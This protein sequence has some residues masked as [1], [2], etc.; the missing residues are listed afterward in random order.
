MFLTRKKSNTTEKDDTSAIIA[1]MVDRTQ[2]T[3]QF[4]PDGTI[5]TANQNF[6]SAL[7]YG[8]EEIQGK[9]H[10]MFVAPELVASND[11]KTF[12]SDLAS[13]KVF[14]DQFPRVTKA[15]ET[16][17]IQATYAPVEDE[18]GKVVRV[19][20]VASDITARRRA[21]DEIGE[22]LEELSG[23][24]LTHRV[25]VSDLPDVG[26]LGKTFN[27]SLEQ[28][29]SSV[30]TVKQVSSA[31]G[32]TAQEISQ[33]A[34][35]LSQRTESQAATLEETAAAIEQ[36][37]ATVK[38]S[39]E[40]AQK[41]DGI[42][43]EAKTSAERSGEV[44]SSAIDAMAQIENSSEQ[45]SKIIGVIDDIAFQ[46]NLLALNAGVEAARAGEAGRGFAVV[47]SEVRALAQRSADAA[48]EIKQ[49]IGESNRQVA[50]GVDLVGKSGEELQ[51]II[52]SVATISEHIQD[53]ATGASEQSTALIE[54]NQGV[55]QLDQ[56]TQQN[57]AMVEQTSAASQMLTNDAC[58][59]TQ[60]VSKF[61]DGSEGPEPAATARKSAPP[62]SFTD[63][64]PG[65][66]DLP[67]AQGWDNF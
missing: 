49:L 62:A 46:T 32:R 53:I 55:A 16:I 35:D 13:G 21:L 63:T 37:S 44:V 64:R 9:H 58:H 14:S 25:A 20:K 47:A 2:A 6:L 45:I 41:V 11:Y 1:G 31:V 17:W 57:A 29:S 52:K 40:G 22:G 42:V 3:I 34:G 19:V 39:A 65:Q 27:H 66:E 61:K 15:G 28:L 7:G 43:T 60:E 5:I 48:G 38:A 23:G 50:A 26:A 18:N 24:N 30:R 51:Q 54:I 67:M 36:L 8:L 59:L 33:S 12:W 4:H 10:S 56:V